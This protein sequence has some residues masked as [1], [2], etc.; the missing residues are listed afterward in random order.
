VF[1]RMGETTGGPSN[2]GT[3]VK[4]NLQT[5]NEGK[6][7]VKV[8]GEFNPANSGNEKE[9]KNGSG[10]VERKKKTLLLQYGRKGVYEGSKK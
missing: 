9:C 4:T 5:S 7:R 3:E 8:D 1:N 10:N 2:G 6:P